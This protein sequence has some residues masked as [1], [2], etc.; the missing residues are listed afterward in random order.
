MDR[1]CLGTRV[2][3][4]ESI[5][6]FDIQEI[7]SVMLRSILKPEVPKLRRAPVGSS[8]IQRSRVFESVV[9]ETSEA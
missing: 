6:K 2:C 8:K 9:G 5:Q 3:R 7:C 1:S 4:I